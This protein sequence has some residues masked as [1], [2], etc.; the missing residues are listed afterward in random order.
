MDISHKIFLTRLFCALLACWA[1]GK[2]LPLPHLVMPM[3]YHITV[4]HRP[5]IF[6]PSAST[7][8]LKLLLSFTA[9]TNYHTRDCSFP[10]VSYLYT[11]SEETK[12]FYILFN[13]ILPSS[14]T[15]CLSTQSYLPPT[16]QR[17]A[18]P[19]FGRM[20]TVWY[21][22]ILTTCSVI[23]QTAP[24]LIPHWNGFHYPTRK[25]GQ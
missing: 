24:F 18:I 22:V 5:H 3:I 7:H 4:T 8:W 16:L 20:N 2:C 25:C 12:I 23:F 17:C 21:W 1:R 14:Q 19:R 13:T 9:I 10:F 6:T 11:L 15:F